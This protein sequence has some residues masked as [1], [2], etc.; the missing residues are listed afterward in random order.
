MQDLKLSYLSTVLGALSS[1]STI[2]PFSTDALKS[3]DFTH[4][5]VKSLPQLRDSQ[6][7]HSSH[8][9]SQQHK[10]ELGK[11]TACL[12]LNIVSQAFA[13]S[14]IQAKQQEDMQSKH[15]IKEVVFMSTDN[16]KEMEYILVLS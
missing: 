8:K 14:I 6:R 11:A 16:Q 2:A 4:D 12:Y 10:L 13:L 5:L 7:Q 1:L 3:L 9:H 15:N